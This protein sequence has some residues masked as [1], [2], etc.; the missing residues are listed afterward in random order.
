MQIAS[1][2][3]NSI[4]IRLPQVLTWLTKAKLAIFALQET[5]VDNANFPLA[6]L[7]TAGYE[8]CFWGQK[9]Y[10][11][12]AILSRLKL[13]DV[14][15]GLPTLAD[16]QCRVISATYKHLRIINV[17]VPNGQSI[18]SEKYHYKLTWLTH[19]HTYLQQQLKHYPQ[20]VVVGDFNIAPSDQDVYDPLA[21][22]GQVL[23][24]KPERTQFQALL[25]LGLIDSFR[26]FKQPENSFS[27]WDYRKGRFARNHGLRLDHLLISAALRPYCKA[28]YID[29][30]WRK[31]KPAS[32]H[33]PVILQLS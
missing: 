21:W 14:N 19:L 16:H 17:Y 12:V 26:L 1:W 28:V 15:L 27:W 8:V 18:N 24:S 9:A 4:R 32:D 22:A 6:A 11:G 30:Q 33:A 3:V 5:K 7:K 25:D 10:N 20:L 2:N 31:V 29:K 13:T 23:C